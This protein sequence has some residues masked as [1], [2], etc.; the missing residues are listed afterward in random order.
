MAGAKLQNLKSAVKWVIDHLSQE[1]KLAITLFDDEVHPLTASTPVTD[2]K[3]LIEKVDA[4]REAGGTAMSKGLLV[5]LDEAMQGSAPDTVSRIIVLTDGQTWG[6]AEKCKELAAQAGAAGIPITAMGVGADEDWSIE[7]L[8]ALAVES[9][10]LSSYIARPEDISSAFEG[11]VLAMQQT[12]ARN[13]RLTINPARGVEI[14]AAYRVA[15]LISRLWPG[16]GAPENAVQPQAEPQTDGSATTVT[17]PLGDIEAG[18]AQTLLFEVMLPPRRPGQYRLAHFLLR[19]EMT[20]RT[21]A[22]G[23]IAL[24]VVATFAPGVMRTP[25]NPRVMN[26]VEKATTLSSRPGPCKQA[27]LAMLPTRPAILERLLLAC[28]ASVRRA[29]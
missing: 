17:L 15:P 23:D 9:G 28:L 20:D 19:Y 4:I 22:Q 26:S 10:G 16:V 1:D 7:L 8:D 2:P 27:W 13:L 5:G 25:G 11:T 21:G 12:V 29:C 3:A 14:R 18:G 6:D 24:D